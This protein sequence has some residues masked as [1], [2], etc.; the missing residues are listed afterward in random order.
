MADTSWAPRRHAA[1]RGALVLLGAVL[2]I[3]GA[4]Y[5]LV[6]SGWSLLPWGLVAVLVGV[7]ARTRGQA[8]IDGSMYGFALA[9][10]FMVA[11]YDGAEPLARRLPFFAL[12]G[13]VGAAC[14]TLLALAG[15]LRRTRHREPRSGDTS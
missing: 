5:V 3:L 7:L 1:R 4:R 8:A 14:A 6:G 9:F 13:L 2:G 11:G 15:T 10:V 12:L